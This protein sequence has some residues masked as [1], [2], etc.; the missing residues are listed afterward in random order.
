M[1]AS[2][3]ETKNIKIEQIKRF[4]VDY[5]R[6]LNKNFIK[7]AEMTP[8]KARL[9]EEGGLDYV[10][11]DGTLAFSIPRTTYEIVEGG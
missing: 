2:S 9:S 10:F 6:Y 5:D 11:S 1:S 3:S 4:K 7:K 8:L